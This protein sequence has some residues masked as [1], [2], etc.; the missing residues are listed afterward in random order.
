MPIRKAGNTNWCQHFH[1]SVSRDNLTYVAFLS[2]AWH[3][4]K[5]VW[6]DKWCADIR[7]VYR[8]HQRLCISNK[9]FKE[10]LSTPKRHD[11]L[12]HCSPDVPIRP[13]R[14]ANAQRDRSRIV[15]PPV[16]RKPDVTAMPQRSQARESTPVSRCLWCDLTSNTP[17]TCN[18]TVGIYF[19]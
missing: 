10:R 19:I 4:H 8:K 3:I 16:E 13:N 6:K 7:K 2:L 17:S 5:T 15:H 1:A 12:C 9:P 14:M 11:A 18:S